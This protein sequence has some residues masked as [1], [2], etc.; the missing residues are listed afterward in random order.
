MIG[1]RMS[2]DVTGV[3]CIPKEVVS[4]G[5]GVNGSIK[6]ELKGW[7][8][9]GTIKRVFGIIC[10][11]AIFVVFSGPAFGITITD[12]FSDGNADGWTPEIIGAEAGPRASWAVQGGRYEASGVTTTDSVI[13][14]HSMLDATA[15]WG[16]TILTVE[17]SGTGGPYPP[18]FGIA[19]RNNG[20]AAVSYIEGYQLWVTTQVGASYVVLSRGWLSGGSYEQFDILQL[21]APLTESSSYWLRLSAV[22]TPSGTHL[23]GFLSSD[24]VNFDKKVEYDDNNINR[25]LTGKCSVFMRQTIGQSATFDN[26]TAVTPE[27]ATLALIGMGTIGLLARRRR[28]RN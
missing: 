10:L 18:E 16:D 25:P 27:P 2:L 22:E 6:N 8:V 7:Y 17:C 4:S 5:N 28:W 15:G 26:V 19:V 13:S 1:N 11:V 14:C 20:Y 21:A 3:A 9:M 23:E 12:D 24:G